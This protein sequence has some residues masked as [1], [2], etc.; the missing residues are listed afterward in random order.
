MIDMAS[1]QPASC[2]IKFFEKWEHKESSTDVSKVVENWWK[3]IRI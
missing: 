2:D 3:Q 1:P